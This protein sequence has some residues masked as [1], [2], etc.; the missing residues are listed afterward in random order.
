MADSDYTY[1][2]PPG[3]GG[4]GIPHTGEY[5]NQG[6]PAVPQG[7]AQRQAPAS[8]AQP[9]L[10]GAVDM[11]ASPVPRLVA[12]AALAL[13]GVMS[14]FSEINKD[15]KGHHTK[16]GKYGRILVGA[17]ATYF[18]LIWSLDELSAMKIGS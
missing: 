13:G 1:T 5:Y 9:H 8:S 4:N 3:H 18:G 17:G 10:G 6:E 2:S 12:S 16:T 11:L 14:V 15:S 7:S